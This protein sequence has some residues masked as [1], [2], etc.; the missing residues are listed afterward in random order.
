MLVVLQEHV[1]TVVNTVTSRRTVLIRQTRAVTSVVRAVISLRIAQI[2]LMMTVPAMYVVKLVTLAVIVPV[3]VHQR[4]SV[5]ITSHAT[6]VRKLVTMH[7][8]ART[9][10]TRIRP[11]VATNAVALVISLASAQPRHKIFLVLLFLYYM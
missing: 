6:G 7:G 5:T 4:R 3:Q 8:N 1:T 10:A 9:T 2:G 11:S